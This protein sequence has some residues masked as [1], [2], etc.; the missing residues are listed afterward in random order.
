MRVCVLVVV[1]LASAA[2]AHADDAEFTAQARELFRVAAC[3]NDAAVPERYPR[4]TIDRHCKRMLDVYEHHH[5]IWVKPVSSFLAKL[6][7]ADA[8][9]TVVYP[10]GGGDLS[11]ALAAFPDA[12]ELTTI[13]LEAAGDIRAIDSIDTKR[14]TADLG[15]IAA[16]IR[17]L[18]RAGHSTTLVLQQASHSRLPGTILFALAGLALHDM[19]PVRLRYFALEPD[20][21]V[22]YLTGA[23]L[24]AR[25]A[26]LVPKR[27]RKRVKHFWYE[28]TSAFA[29]VEIQFKKR[30]DAKAP[31]RTY[32]HILANLDDAHQTDDG[33]VLAHLKAKGSVSVMTKAASFLLWSD[34]FSKVRD[35]LLANLAWMVSDATG[36]PPRFASKAGLEQITY[37][38]FTGPY[39]VQDPNGERAD[40]IKLWAD[41]PARELPFRFGYP[42]KAKH[43]HLLITRPTKADA[44]AAQ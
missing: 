30:G 44:H 20:G 25:A 22:T 32:R 28:Q 17:R 14:L 4:Q 27:K 13:S 42:D 38:Q 3:G 16:G 37:G 31:V 40:F 39:F 1:A 33:R 6:R 5:G 34:D 21:G 35:Y 41:Q 19:E 12:T 15:Q 2:P 11:S 18:Y 26:A 24:D 43:D 9:T 8:P 23:E 29:N 36:I 10:F 7:P